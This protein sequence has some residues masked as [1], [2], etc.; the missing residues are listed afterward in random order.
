MKLTTRQVSPLMI[1]VGIA[2]LTLSGCGVSPSPDSEDDRNEGNADAPCVVGTWDLDVAEYEASSIGYFASL[3][4]PIQ[5]FAMEGE[6]TIR[7]VEEG[8]VASE[9]G[10]RMTGSIVAGEVSVPFD[11]PSSY[12]G[13]GDWAT[14]TSPDTIDF[15]NWA[16]V[17]G[18][19]ES[20]DP[21]APSV[22]TIDYSSMPSVNVQCTADTL[23]IQA[24]EAPFASVWHR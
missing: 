10:L 4:L 21:L 20:G 12:Q 13:S 9:I 22:P 18:S 11:T 6:G 23:R 24:P 19:S 1:L 5:D 3:G 8:L 7:F 17:P 15:S 16:T 2:A 14:G